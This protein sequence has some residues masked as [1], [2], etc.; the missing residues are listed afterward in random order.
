MKSAASISGHHGL[1]ITLG[2]AAFVATCIAIAPASLL[3]AFAG[4]GRADVSYNSIE[5]TIW[6]GKVSRL[7]ADGALIGDVDFRISPFSLI[8]LS[9]RAYVKSTNGAVRG[10]GVVTIGAGQRISVSDA[11]LEVDLGPFARRGVLG[12]PVKGEARVRI[13]EVRLSRRGCV[14]AEGDVWTNVLEAPARQYQTDGFPLSGD[15][16][17]DGDDFVLALSGESGDGAAEMSI[18][19]TPDFTYELTASVRPAEDNV[20]STLRFFG[21]EDNDGALIYGSAGVLRGVGS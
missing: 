11:N 3:S 1:L 7:T 5:G 14:R 18:R 17:C 19:L 16:S 4:Q 10:E 8:G 12:M 13:A 20:A 21:F 15:V 9:P 2:V 6:R